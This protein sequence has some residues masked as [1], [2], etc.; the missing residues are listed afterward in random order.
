MSSH[1]LR[2]VVALLA[3]FALARPAHAQERPNV[4]K[5]SYDV[6]VDFAVTLTGLVWYATS[7]FIKGSLV[8]EK[9]RWCYRRADGTDRLNLVDRSIRRRLMWKKPRTAAVISNILAFG[10]LPATSFGLT[11][12]AALHDHASR[13]IPIDGLLQAEATMLALDLNQMVK[14][15]FARERPFVHFL[16]RAP[17][18]VRALTAS[19]SDD[20]L[21]FF[22]GHT[23]LAFALASSSGTIASLRNYRLA[24]MVWGSGLATA[25][26]V[27]YL[28]IAADKHYFSDVVVAAIFGTA[29]GAGIPLLLH[30]P[31]RDSSASG[32][33]SSTNGPSPNPS[34]TPTTFSISGVW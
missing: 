26:A 17:E 27:G 14:Y 6:R 4:R 25:A 23:T 22:S 30:R 33:A 29:I 13:E 28:R 16:P 11:Q 21:S 8:P 9:C 24:P 5:L 19:P 10:V 12:L 3:C 34:A 15:A 18:G 7:E 31:E 1:R 2:L 20:N 32:G